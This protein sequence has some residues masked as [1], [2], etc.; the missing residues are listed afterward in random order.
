MNLRKD[1]SLEKLIAEAPAPGRV[2][3]LGLCLVFLLITAGTLIADASRDRIFAQRAETAFDHARV[4]FQ[5]NTND[6]VVAW[7]FARACFDWADCATNKSD[8]AAIARE[9]MDACQQSLR[10]TNSAAAHYY[11]GLNMGRLAQADKFHGLKL[12]EKM[13]QE[14]KTA[15]DLDPHFYFAGPE[16]SLGL[17][18]LNAPAWPLSIGSQ[19]KAREFL[20]QAAAAAPDYPDN[21]LNLAELYLKA[22]DQAAAKKE[23]DALNA[24]WPAAQKD[25]AGEDWEQNWDEWSKR[26][27]DLREALANP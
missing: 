20:E 10:L 2:S 4:Q 14:F 3:F 23:L 22:G 25:L 11:L 19:E 18:Y 9:G 21:L 6:P 15:I 12:V 17:L 1:K 24:L 8:R 5:S 13:E 7:E 26:R 27:D 16:R